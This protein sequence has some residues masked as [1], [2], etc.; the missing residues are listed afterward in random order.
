MITGATGSQ[1]MASGQKVIDMADGNPN[2]FN[3]LGCVIVPKILSA[4]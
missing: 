2:D 1:N 3:K 4:I